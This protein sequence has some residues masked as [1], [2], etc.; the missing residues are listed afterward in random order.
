MDRFRGNNYW[1]NGFKCFLKFWFWKLWIAVLHLGRSGSLESYRESKLLYRHPSKAYLLVCSMMQ[2]SRSCFVWHCF[3]GNGF[4]QQS[5]DYAVST[6]NDSSYPSGTQILISQVL[7]IYRDLF[8]SWKCW[9]W[10]WSPL[11]CISNWLLLCLY[12]LVDEWDTQELKESIWLLQKSF[13][14]C[15]SSTMLMLHLLLQAWKESIFQ[16][17]SPLRD[18]LLLLFWLLGFC[19]VK[20]NQQLR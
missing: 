13:F 17:I 9:L 2:F 1:F 14:R 6:F 11:L 20:A 18:S 5:C 19:L 4:Y 3:Y 7:D 10:I 16:C 8:T 12:T 15:P